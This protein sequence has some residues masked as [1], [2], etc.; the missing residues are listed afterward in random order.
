[1]K[2]RP[3][4]ESS[5]S[6]GIVNA[7]R[8]IAGVGAPSTPSTSRRGKFDNTSL[9]IHHG[10]VDQATVTSGAP[11]EVFAHVAKV[12]LGMGLEMQKETEF[13]YRCIR[14]KKRKRDG[15]DGFGR[16]AS[17]AGSG[18]TAYTMVGSAASNGVRTALVAAAS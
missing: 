5:G 12:L 15:K 17:D 11:P 7:V 18:Y 10:A 1:V 14:P 9:R 8:T 3:P 13:K 16:Q 2:S 6:K 4:S